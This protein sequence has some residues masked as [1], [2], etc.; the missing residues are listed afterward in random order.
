MKGWYVIYTKSR[1]EK[2][3]AQILTEQN[4]KVYLPLNKTISQWSDRKKKVEKPL[5][6]SYV[7]IYLETIKDYLRALAIEGVVIFIKFGNRLVRVLDE[8]I[9][10]IRVFLNEFS[11]VELRNSLDIK[12]GEKRRISSGPFENYDC[13]IIKIDNKKKICVRIES[14]KYSILAEMHSYHLI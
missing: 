8:E 14:L 7:F 4:F 3:T 11:D 12:V 6:S 10:R 5:F 13:E 9:D 1:Y 2:K